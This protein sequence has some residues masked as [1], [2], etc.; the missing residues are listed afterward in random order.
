M[1]IK[2]QL[3]SITLMF[4]INFV[5]C[6]YLGIDPDFSITT[7]FDNGMKESSTL[8]LAWVLMWWG[9]PPYVGYLIIEEYLFFKSLSK[10]DSDLQEL[11]DLQGAESDESSD[12]DI[13][14]WEPSEDHDPSGNAQYFTADLPE[15]KQ[16]DFDFQSLFDLDDHFQNPEEERKLAEEDDFDFQSL[17]E[18]SEE[19]DS[20][21]E[22]SEEDF[23]FQSLFEDSEEDPC[24]DSEEDS[25]DFS[26]L[27]EDSEE[28]ISDFDHLF[29]DSDWDTKLE[30]SEEENER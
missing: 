5:T 10:V 2:L 6:L 8:D 22:D 23:D 11:K 15:G 30:M 13:W 4:T 18:D 21:E 7:R 14:N 29:F 19:D 16:E 27:V 25:V 12:D 26:H 24:E 28:E 1:S 17:F 20:E 3:L 9:L